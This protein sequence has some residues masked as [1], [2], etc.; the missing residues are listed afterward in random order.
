MFGNRYI[1][2]GQ[3]MKTNNLFHT[4]YKVA[5]FALPISAGGIISAITGFISIM[6]VALLGKEQLAAGSLAISTFMTIMTVTATI[7]YSVGILISHHRSQN[8]TPAEI[9]VIVKN[10][11]WLAIFLMPSMSSSEVG[12]GKKPSL[13]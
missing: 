7:F 2:Y 8:K 9:G 10:G 11:F 5:V 4:M 6:M 1:E 13:S 3:T 12:S